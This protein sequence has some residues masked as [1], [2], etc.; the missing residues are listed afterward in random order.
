MWQELTVYG[1]GIVILLIIARK[2]IHKIKGV[3]K[4]EVC[5][6]CPRCETCSQKKIYKLD[7][8]SIKK[9]PEYQRPKSEK[10]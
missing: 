5:T 4:N 3:K 10:K 2:I 1:I 8:K 6:G 7:N 9:C